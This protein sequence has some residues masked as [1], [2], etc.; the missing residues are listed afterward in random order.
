MELSDLQYRPVLGKVNQLQHPQN[1]DRFFDKFR[2]PATICQK[3]VGRRKNITD[4]E[5]YGLV[6]TVKFGY[7]VHM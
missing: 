4:G 6:A 7:T 3:Q 2:S 5:K 1:P